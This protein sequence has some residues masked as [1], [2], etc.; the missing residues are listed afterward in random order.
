MKRALIT[1]FVLMT[2]SIAAQPFG[3]GRARGLFM[4]IAIGPRF[5]ISEFAKSHDLGVGINV[6]FAYTD[7]EYI[8]LFFYGQIGYEHYPGSSDYYR[9]TDYAAISTN[10][11]PL[12]VGAKIFLPPLVNNI[13]LLI[14]TIQFGASGVMLGKQ[15]QFKPGTLRS[16]YNENIS[17]LG[18]QIS[19]GFSMF[20]VEVM[21]SYNYFPNNEYLSG[22]LRMRVPIYIKL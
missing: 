8:P 10:A 6:E 13:V 2:I 15:H 17:K 16:N 19:A 7:N 1:V 22:D 3:Q 21:A 14:P 18:F 4:S 9:H 20:L 12:N 5:P 11:I